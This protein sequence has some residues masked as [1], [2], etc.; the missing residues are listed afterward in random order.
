MNTFQ[1]PQPH[2]SLTSVMCVRVRV[3]AC[4]RVCVK[5]CVCVCVC[6]GSENCVYE[7]EIK[8][9]YPAINHLLILFFILLSVTWVLEH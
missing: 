8:G 5:G 7:T 9:K 1:N 4:V 6:G 2:F 3:R